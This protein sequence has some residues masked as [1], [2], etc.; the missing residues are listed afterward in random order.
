MG[1]MDLMPISLLRSEGLDR[2]N[3]RSLVRS[4]ALSRARRGVYVQAQQAGDRVEQN[5]IKLAA[6]LLLA[7]QRVVAS[8]WSAALL[9]G[10]PVPGEYVGTIWLTAPGSGG[11]YFRHGVR[12]VVTRLPAGD[13]CLLREIRVTSLARTVSDLVRATSFQQGVILADAAL[14][15]GMKASD[16]QLQLDAVAGRKGVRPGR[17]V[18]EFADGRAES[19][20]ESVTRVA[21]RRAGVRTP[22]LQRNIWNERGDWVARVD[23]CWDEE[24][25]VGEYDGE[26]KYYLD[27]D[28]RP[29]EAFAA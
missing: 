28:R 25:L 21:I 18:A 23:F 22:D 7:G 15:M 13:T 16:L 3:I 12:K 11:G 6:A 5:R 1:F 4:G 2:A 26:D 10:L 14:R 24:R 8:H 27:A 19:P 9:W 29:T 20:M 17:A